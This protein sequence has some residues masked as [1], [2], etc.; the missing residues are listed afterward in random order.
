MTSQPFESDP[1][2]ENES[3]PAISFKEAPVG[4][5]VTGRVTSPAR[6]VQSKDFETGERAT[7]PDGNPKM[8]AV[9]EMDTPLGPRSLWASKPSALFAA[10]Q[11]AQK[12]AGAR[13]TPGGTLTVT[14]THDVPNSRNPRLNPAKQYSVRYVPPDAFGE[15]EPNGAA[16]AAA[17]PWGQQPVQPAPRGFEQPYAAPQ[18]QWPA[19]APAAPA[20]PSPWQPAPPPPPQRQQDAE[21]PF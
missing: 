2:A 7:W 14:Y 1:F 8:A 16:T 6:L 19:Q 13:I 9:I 11:Q 18:Q 4:S 21:P 15:P 12:A 20:A 3:L 10:I 17:Q 5:S